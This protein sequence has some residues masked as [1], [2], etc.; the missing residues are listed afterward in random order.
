MYI[1]VR[2]NMEISNYQSL[3][4][5]AE[6]KDLLERRISGHQ[7]DISYRK[8]NSWNE[9]GLLPYQTEIGK[10]RIFSFL[11]ACWVKLI[12]ILRDFGLSIRTIKRLKDSILEVPD[13]KEAFK[14]E[15]VKQELQNQVGNEQAE[16]VIS[17]FDSLDYEDYKKWFAATL[18]GLTILTCIY[19]RN[20][21]YILVTSDGNFFPVH[22]SKLDDSEYMEAAEDFKRQP[23]ICI[24][25]NSIVA[26]ILLLPNKHQ[27]KFYQKILNKEENE[28]IRIARTHSSRKKIKI[29]V[30][31]ED[32]EKKFY[33]TILEGNQIVDPGAQ[34]TNIILKG[35]YKEI[36]LEHEN[37]IIKNIK[38][39]E[40][41]E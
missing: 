18:F 38:R 13:L 15:I 11:E 21:I 6:F 31:N 30:I 7:L 37:E 9:L 17:I 33:Y 23:H 4:K 28:L 24:L 16:V 29:Q 5:M 19:E 14:N 27:T 2:L 41:P 36:S 40:N 34:L 10:R 8:I 12:K 35:N 1:Y 26:E 25:L 22:Q 32:G 39:P 20:P 3:P